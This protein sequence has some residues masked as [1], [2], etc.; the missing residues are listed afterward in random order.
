MSQVKKF[1]EVFTPK[2]IVDKLLDGIDYS[3]PD[4]TICEPSFGD[5]RILLEV[6]TRLL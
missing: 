4:L 3:N 6:K 2:H 5:G 1:G